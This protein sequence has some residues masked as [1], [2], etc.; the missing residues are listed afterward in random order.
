MSAYVPYCGLPP[1]PGALVWNLD[2]VLIL[3]LVVACGVHLAWLYRHSAGRGRLGAASAGW[4]IVALALISPLCN[5]SVALFSARVAQH[6]IILLIGAPLIAWGS[7]HVADSDHPLGSSVVGPVL[8]FAAAIWLWHLPGPYDATLRS[9]VVY[10]TMHLTL[11][12][13]AVWLWDVLLNDI[14]GRIG[15]SLIAT[16]LTA[17]QMSILGAILTLAPHP[18]FAVHFDTTA[19]WG[20]MPLEDQQLGGLIMWVPAGVLLTFY[21]LAGF[22][23]QLRRLETRRRATLS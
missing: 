8:A 9:D 22:G 10:W 6:M 15:V 18:L 4:V 21:A 1:V 13:A 3:G 14:S 17:L 19:A 7:G 2:P 16:F 5:L 23:L 12:G 11:F 20:F